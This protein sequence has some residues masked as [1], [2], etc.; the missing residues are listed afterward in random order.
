MER[1]TKA[2]DPR[3]GYRVKV[4][5][6]NN[7]SDRNNR[8]RQVSS[9]YPTYLAGKAPYFEVHAGNFKTQAEANAAA[10]RIR[11]RFPAFAAEVRVVKSRINP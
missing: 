8:M 3:Q 9:M 2:V 5:K 10:A 7:T 1:K 11:Q 4:Y 6:G